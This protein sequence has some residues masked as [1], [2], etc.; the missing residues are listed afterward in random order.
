MSELANIAVGNKGVYHKAGSTP[1]S[2]NNAVNF[3]G[4]V[5]YYDTNKQ[6]PV[7]DS[8]VSQD[9]YPYHAFNN[10]VGVCIGN[11]CITTKPIAHTIR[12]TNAGAI[13]TINQNSFNGRAFNDYVLKA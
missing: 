13:F 6:L 10:I 12:S 1:T 5:G 4:G 3:G 2:I 8:T 9:D 11:K 7:G